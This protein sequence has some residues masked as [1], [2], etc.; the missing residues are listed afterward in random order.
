[1]SSP[2]EVSRLSDVPPVVPSISFVAAGDVLLD[3]GIARKIK[4]NG[5]DWPF[6]KVARTIREADLAFCNLEC[7]LS[8]DGRKVNKPICFKAPPGNLKCVKDAGFDIVSTANNHSLDCGRTGL[9]ETMRLLDVSRIA[10]AGSGT[11]LAE[12]SAPRI[13]DIGGVK[14]AFLVRNMLFP[15]MVWYRTD[16]PTIAE[17]NKATIEDEIRAAKAKADVVVVSVHWGI[18]YRKHPE[19]W[20]RE[21][22]HRMIDAGASLVLGHHPHCTQPVERY[23]GGVIAYSLGNFLFDSRNPVCMETMILK[24]RL[25]RDGV[26]DL[27]IL[28]A[29]IV[30]WRPTPA[31][32]GENVHS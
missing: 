29:R 23:H 10:H 15:E 1:M 3:R 8:A 28:P 7:P 24:C 14:V 32:R 19:D 2:T 20:Q 17:L 16:V 30:N 21:L 13:M 12:A 25:S 26:S 9:M 4:A 31:Q 6:A 22:G 5:M 27:E 11:N 18:E